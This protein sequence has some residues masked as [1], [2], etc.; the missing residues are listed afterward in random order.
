MFK[1]SQLAS[2]LK[3]YMVVSC[4]L[5]LSACKPQVS[6][7]IY[8]S[9]ILEVA[10]TGKALDVPVR[11]GLP[12]QDEKK[13]D[14]DKNKMLPALQR[15]GTGIKFV[16]CEDLSG[17]M[18]D[19]LIVEMVGK[20]IKEPASGVVTIEGMFGMSV[21]QLE[22]GSLVVYFIK[23]ENVDKAIAEIDNNY[24]FQ[25]IEIEDLDLK[26]RLNN[27]MRKTIKFEIDGSYVDNNPVDA[28]TIFEI[29]HRGIKELVPS[30]VRSQSIIK[31]GKAK[32]VR[33]IVD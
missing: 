10:E 15:Y 21:S 33:L 2:G 23:T 14:E 27:D 29:P 20:V 1:Q 8:A 32:F 22:D 18:H 9:D 31:T 16:S 24:Q 28:P 30:N 19:L 4:I 12:I 11:M 7:D 13:C 6:T 3:C 25:D 26:V 17:E 5:L